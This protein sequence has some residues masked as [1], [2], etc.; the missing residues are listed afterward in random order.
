MKKTLFLFIAIMFASC[1]FAQKN[2]GLIFGYT[3]KDVEL[4]YTILSDGKVYVTSQVKTA[5]PVTKIVVPDR[6]KDKK[7]KW[8]DVGGACNDAFVGFTAVKT[9]FFEAVKEGTINQRSFVDCP[10]LEIV[11]VGRG[12][13]TMGDKAF[14][15]CPKMKT[16]FVPKE[17][18]LTGNKMK[19]YGTNKELKIR[20][21][22][23]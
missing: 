18:V 5:K 7:G 8:Y 17:A 12:Y 2:V 23:Y 6:V 20:I 3:Y 1:A 13:T 10:N 9:I 15:N 19:D 21:E 4:Y 22:K 14:K 11:K 16:L